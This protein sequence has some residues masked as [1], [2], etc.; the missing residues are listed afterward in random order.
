RDPS[1][2]FRA[3]LSGNIDND[4]RTGRLR[5]EGP[6][7][8]NATA[9]L[10]LR[11]YKLDGPWTNELTGGPI[12]DESTKS[13]ETVLN[14][15]PSEN[16]RIRVRGSF[17]KDDDGTRPLFFQ[18]GEL[19]NCYPGTR[20][21]ASF[22]NNI[23]PST[24]N[25]QYYCGTIQP[26]S[27]LYLN[28]APVT[29]NIVPVPGFPLTAA[30]TPAQGAV[31]G[32]NASTGFGLYQTGQ[33]MPISGVKR[34]LGLG[35]GLI[36]W[37]I[38]GSGYT[39]TVNGGLR[40]EKRF[41]GSDSDHSAINIISAPINGAPNLANGAASDFV[42]FEDF[43]IEAKIASPSEN[44]LRWLL[45]V[46][47]YEQDND[48]TAVDFFSPQGQ[49]SPNRFLDIY[50]LAAFGS[51]EFDF[52]DN[53]S[54][55][56]ELRRSEETVGLTDLSTAGRRNLG[57]PGGFLFGDKREFKSTTPR[58][59]ID[60]RITPDVTI[61]AVYAEGNK[62]GGF[63]GAVALNN[64]RPNDVT[65]RPEEAQS[66]ELGIK[67]NLGRRATVS[68]AI[69]N[70][71][72]TDMQLTTPIQNPASGALTSIVTN[73]GSGVSKGLEFESSFAVTENLK[74][75]LNYALADTKF[76]EGCDDFQYQLTSGGG[77]YLAN[78]PAFS[79]NFTGRGSCSIVG[80]PFPLTSKHT[81]SLT[82][83]YER[84]VF[85]GAMD[86]YWNSDLSYASKKPVQVHADPWTGAATLLGMRLGFRTERWNVGLYGRNLLNEDSVVSATRWLHQFLIGVPS[87][88]DPGLPPSTV[89]PPA[90]SGIVC[91]MA[92]PNCVPWA[93]YSL[94]R[95]FFGALRQPRQVGIE[96]TFNFGG[97]SAP[98][99]VRVAD[100]DGDGV[101][102]D[103][104]RCPGT[105]AG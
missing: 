1:E 39:L 98:R 11:S 40:T 96:A 70:T 100:S 59:T 68:L 48:S 79:A 58:F 8:E 26:P 34:E 77:A 38:R 18:S 88:L 76:T 60:W 23:T 86:F 36:E 93:Q 43:S 30:F 62:P 45:G 44:R 78:A 57:S 7:G 16:V 90:G 91:P 53:L 21:I 28:D 104:D 71:D 67:A 50:N 75:G 33:A 66:A 103:I 10:L 52:T 82:V 54:G 14:I 2:T 12:G 84:P 87:F 80:N 5:I 73:Q 32:L 37:N 83:D 42:R 35:T 22:A 105:P 101:T 25:F 74:I 9:S 102:D 81:G 27:R 24:N 65:F 95:G 72:V 3:K 4:E 29:R 47:H 17:N 15:R 13:V 46:Y 31:L 55:T 41:T 49:S 6:I 94:P 69:F 51:L 89:A 63:N 97:E 92:T 56:V 19:N 64:G 85:D 99:Q 20:S 61:Y